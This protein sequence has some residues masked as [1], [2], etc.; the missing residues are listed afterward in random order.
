MRDNK[1]NNNN[2]FT[3]EFIKESQAVALAGSQAGKLKQS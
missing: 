1:N 3:N 2:M